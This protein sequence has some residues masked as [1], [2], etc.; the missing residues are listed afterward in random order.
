MRT[1]DIMD[2][3]SVSNSREILQLIAIA[4]KSRENLEFH[5]SIPDSNLLVSSLSPNQDSLRSVVNGLIYK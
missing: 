5:A 2:C 4:I 1:V 3:N